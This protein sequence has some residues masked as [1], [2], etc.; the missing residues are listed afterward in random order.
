ML[1]HYPVFELFISVSAKKGQ[2]G[3]IAQACNI[4]KLQRRMWSSIN[5]DDNAHCV[6]GLLFMQLIYVYLVPF[7]KDCLSYL[8]YLLFMYAL[9]CLSSVVCLKLCSSQPISLWFETPVQS[10]AARVNEVERIDCC[11]ICPTKHVVGIHPP[12]SVVKTCSSNLVVFHSDLTSP[13][14]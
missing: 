10:L 9:F 6:E 12:G 14:E 5:N 13:T 1:C 3:V 2:A 7:A 4:G 11:E 8:L